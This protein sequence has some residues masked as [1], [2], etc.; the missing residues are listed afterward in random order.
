MTVAGVLSGVGLWTNAGTGTLTLTGT[1]TFTNPLNISSGT[2][3]SRSRPSSERNRTVLEAAVGDASGCLSAQDHST[4]TC[5]RYADSSM[6]TTWG[7]DTGP[8]LTAALIISDIAGA[9]TCVV[10]AAKPARSTSPSAALAGLGFDRSPILKL[11]APTEL[12]ACRASGT[13][14]S[15]RESIS[16][17]FRRARAEPI[18]S[19]S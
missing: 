4:M 3:I 12:I 16:D 18:A 14:M 10:S 19:L 5:P 9:S 13:S 8:A 6:P 7:S 15:R 1:N 11:S 2:A 17:V